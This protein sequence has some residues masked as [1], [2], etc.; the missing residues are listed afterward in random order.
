[1]VIDVHCHV[2]LSARRAAPDVPRFFFEA[3]GAAGRPGYDSYFSPRLIARWQWWVMRRW[4]GIDPSL[5][6]GDELDAAIEAFNERHWAEMPGVDRLVLLAFDEYRDDAGG[7]IGPVEPG[8]RFGTDLFV[9]NTFVRSMCS[10]RPD[11][12]LFGGS[13]HPYRMHGD[14]DAVSLLEEVAGAGCVLI[15][16]LPI[17]QNIRI[18]DARSVAFLR[19]AARLGVT[20]LIHYGGEMSLAR[21]HMEFESPLPLLEVLRKLRAEGSMPVVIVAH[22]ATP[23]FAWQRST[24]FAALV[25]SM[26]GEFG[27]D[28]LYAD[29]SALAAPCRTVWLR[30]L[31]AMPQSHRKLVWG[32]DFPIP[33]LIR[34]F[35][36]LL[37][38]RTRQELR[39]TASW[40]ERDLRLKR[41]LGF[42][43]GVFNRAA[44]LLG[45]E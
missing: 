37:D 35:R 42:D 16:W 5:K 40:V 22:V 15:K 30:R 10:Q 39:A 28:G 3:A 9:S 36:R 43:E 29:I 19:A 6:A 24:G 7:V 17:H 44:G 20:M 12:Y 25:E 31:A 1:M 14:R 23:S 33:V 32:T 2:G 21:Q 13:I 8:G 18:D 34:P 4:L 45:V 11:R 41:A 27:D 38:R 26:L